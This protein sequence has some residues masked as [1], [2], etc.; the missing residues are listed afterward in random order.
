MSTNTAQCGTTEAPMSDQDLAQAASNAV[1]SL[2]E[3]C[4]RAEKEAAHWHKQYSRVA[5]AVSRLRRALRDVNERY[6]EALCGE[7]EI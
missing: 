6:L 5:G 1:D 2:I 4:Q 7:K 3:R